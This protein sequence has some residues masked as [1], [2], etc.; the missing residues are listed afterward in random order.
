MNT[1][2][3]PIPLKP[4]KENAELQMT[5]GNPNNSGAYTALQ[6]APK[7]LRYLMTA[8]N[9]RGHGIHSPFVFDFVTQV[10]CD[11]ERYPEYQPIEALRSALLADKDTIIPTVDFGAG[12]AGS[13]TAG[14]GTAGVGTAGAPHDR[15]TLSSIARTALKPPRF[16]QLFFRIARHYMPSTVLE[17]GT[18]L[19]ITTAYLACG[20]PESSVTTLEGAP[21]I[22]AS[23]RK[24]FEHLGLHRIR[25]LE[26]NF[27]DTLERALWQYAAIDLAYIDG[28][29]RRDPTLRYFMQ[30]QPKLHDGSILIFDDIHWSPGMEEAWETLKQDPLVTC[31]VDLFYIGV[32]FFRKEF[33]I[34]QHFTVR[35]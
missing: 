14:A 25:L 10:L 34:K 3:T 16:G 19:G 2:H 32:L 12:T 35:F 7:Y 22:A 26:G 9:G 18:S 28:N 8:S 1:T 23:A 24:H 6:L 31:S 5:T 30:M 27:D 33:H 13:G 29:H 21:A 11:R 17:L 15:R 4:G 20:S